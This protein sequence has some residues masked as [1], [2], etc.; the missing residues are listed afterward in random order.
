MGRRRRGLLPWGNG[1]PGA[2]P[3]LTMP[4]MPTPTKAIYVPP[5]PARQRRA[6][7]APTYRLVLERETPTGGVQMHAW[8]GIPHERVG[9]LLATMQTYLPFLVRAAAAR[10]AFHKVLDLFR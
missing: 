2:P 3:G 5:G 6:V 9:P 8:S 10:E 7:R 4:P 1:C